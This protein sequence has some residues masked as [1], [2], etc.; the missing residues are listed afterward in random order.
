MIYN[1]FVIDNGCS[2][3]SYE[4][5][6]NFGLNDQL[7]SGFLSAISSFAQETFNTGLMTIQIRNG[8]KLAF[9][10]A[11]EYKLLLCAIA[12]GRDNDHLLEKILG[13]I[14]AKFTD[15]MQEVLTSDLKRARID[16]YKPF[17]PILKDLM[18]LKTKPRNIKSMGMG[19][20]SGF[21]ALIGF[22]SLI[23]TIVAEMRTNLIEESV[24]LISFLLL[25]SGS[26]SLCSLISGYIAG[27]SKMGL[28]NGVIFFILLNILIL[29]LNSSLFIS[30]LYISPFVL[31]ACVASGYAGGYLCDRRNLY[32][33]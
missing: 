27:N 7:L 19:I 4:F 30:F 21:I 2:I 23:Y 26:L 9:Y 12:D 8:Q 33:L 28:K 1:L 20:L 22:A 5:K 17:D 32:P 24:V 11:S 15:V 14:S 25:L 18:K 16:L 3:Y 10:F 31:I 6:K 13:V 29:V